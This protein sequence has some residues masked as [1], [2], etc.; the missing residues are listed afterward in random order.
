MRMNLARR[1][2]PRKRDLE[3]L[4]F[5]AT[6]PVVKRQ[7]RTGVGR[8]E[9]DE[10]IIVCGIVSQYNSTS[11]PTTRES[12]YGVMS[13]VRLVG[14]NLVMRRF[15]VGHRMFGPEH[16]RDPKEKTLRWIEEGKLQAVMGE[17]LPDLV[18]G[19]AVVTVEGVLNL[20]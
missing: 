18:I 11:K 20:W 13:L 15:Q 16:M 3:R 5:E 7:R 19:S 14:Q 4:I 1:P 10:R 2:E 12:T 6:K 8:I 9:Q 17:L